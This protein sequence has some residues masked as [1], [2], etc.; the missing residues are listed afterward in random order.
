MFNNENVKYN[1]PYHSNIYIGVVED[2]VDPLNQG[3]VRV[4]I[5]GFHTDIKSKSSTEGLL[6][7]QLPWAT[8]GNPIQG[9]S[10]S[11]IGWS[12][13]P[14]NGSHVALFFIGGDHNFPIYFATIGGMYKTKPDSNKGFSD[15][16]GKFPLE[17][18]VPDFNSLASTT[19]TVFDTPDDGPRV[20][21]ESL[22][23][24]E[25]WKV[26]IKTNNSS[27]EI[28]KNGNVNI[29]TTGDIKLG[30]GADKAVMLKSIIT[31]FNNHG[32][33]ALGSPPSAPNLFDNTDTSPNVLAKAGT[34]P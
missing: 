5:I 20:E 19:K 34:T 7:E 15:P 21:Y 32:H 26:T 23:G 9:G 25:S 16:S 12:G 4:R 10:M 2:N 31:K 13:V 27:I 17:T 3:R 6:T 1:N 30:T 11:G 18:N 28:D 24:S 22:T 14:V 29:I 33:P 8:P